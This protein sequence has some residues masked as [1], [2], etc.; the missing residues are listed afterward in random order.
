M[1]LIGPALSKIFMVMTVQVPT[2]TMKN[3]S[4]DWLTFTGWSTNHPFNLVFYLIFCY[5]AAIYAHSCLILWFLSHRV[6]LDQS[7]NLSVASNVSNNFQVL[8]VTHNYRSII[9]YW[10]SML[11]FG[12][13]WWRQYVELVDKWYNKIHIKDL[14]S[15]VSLFLFVFVLFL[16][17]F[18]APVT[19]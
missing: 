16:F 1:A 12:M 19:G 4:I 11:S 14:D 13:N 18:Y 10:L 5:L 2:S 7:F 3:N 15:T 9:K 8:M 6:F 17:L